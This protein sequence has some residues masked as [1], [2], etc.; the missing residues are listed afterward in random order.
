MNNASLPP[1]LYF[2]I[3]LLLATNASAAPPQVITSIVPLRIIASE[4]M[5]GVGNVEMLVH[6]GSSPHE[7]RLYPSAA[8]SIKNADLIIWIGPNLENKLA[9]P[10]LKLA[11]RKSLLTLLELDLPVKLNA[12]HEGSATNPVHDH[13]LDQIDPHIWLSPDNVISISNAIYRKLIDIDPEN[14]VTYKNN[15]G[16][17]QQLIEQSDKEISARLKTVQSGEYAILHNSIAY[18]AKHYSLNTIGGLTV[19]S[20]TPNSTKQLAQFKKRIRLSNV[21]CLLFEQTPD[22]SLIQVIIEGLTINTAAIDPLGAYLSDKELSYPDLLENLSE[23]II[24]CLT[25]AP[26]NISNAAPEG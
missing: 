13:A 20:H 3:L 7:F 6:A 11:D 4:L 5:R 2:L 16:N 10:L 19:N 9:R 18:F 22:D 14:A 1:K 17:F 15:L 12:F 24:S 8:L 21:S 25:P 26:Q 23:A